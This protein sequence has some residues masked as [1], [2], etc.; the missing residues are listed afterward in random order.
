MKKRKISVQRDRRRY[1]IQN[2]PP[3][4]TTWDLDLIYSLPFQ[5][6]PHPSYKE[7]IPA[8]ETVMTSITSHRG[9][10]GS[11]SFCSLNL[12][13]G[14]QVISRNEESILEEVYNLT[15]RNDFKGTIN[16]VGG[17]TANMYKL[18]CK[19]YGIPGS[20]TNRDCLFPNMGHYLEQIQETIRHFPLRYRDKVPFPF[21]KL[22]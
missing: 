2:P 10:F 19:L 6:F 11:C 20:C 5:R 9:R 3:V 12:H 21:G 8:L 17:P 1:I 15:K 13:Q 22:F 7:K 4:Y 14:W 16:D 18:R